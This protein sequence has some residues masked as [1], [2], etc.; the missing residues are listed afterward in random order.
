[1]PTHFGRETAKIYQFPVRTPANADARRDKYKSALDL[2]CVQIVETSY[3]S[4]WYHE[5]AIRDSERGQKN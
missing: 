4:S 5:A 1:M 2:S 3:G